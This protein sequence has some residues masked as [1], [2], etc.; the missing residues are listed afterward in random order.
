MQTGEIEENGN[1]RIFKS[2]SV[3]VSHKPSISIAIAF[4]LDYI[5]GKDGAI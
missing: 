3:K 4:L 5:S 1:T 2:S